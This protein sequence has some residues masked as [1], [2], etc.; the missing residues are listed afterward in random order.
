MVHFKTFIFLERV[1]M[2]LNYKNLCKNLVSE[3]QKLHSTLIATELKPASGELREFQLKTFDFCKGII[4]KLEELNLPYFPIG[5]TLIGV[6]RH[7]GFVPWDDDFD[8]GMMRSD[9]DSFLDF[10][11]K[12]YIQI[13]SGE[14]SFNLENREYVWNKYMKKY[15]NKHIFLQTPHHTQ[16]IFGTDINNFVN[17]D[18]F[19]HDYYDESLSLEEYNIYINEIKEK[20]EIISN[21][22][23]VLDFYEKER[24][25]NPIFVEKSNKIYY[26]LDNIDNYI[27]KHRGFFSVD[28]IFP[29]RR[30]KFED[31]EIWVQN[32][33]LEY[34]ELQYR[35]C[36]SMPSDIIISPHIDA[37]GKRVKNSY[38]LTY[39][40][41]KVYRLL[42]KLCF[43][44]INEK[45]AVSKSLVAQEL[46]TILLEP[47]YNYKDAY[48]DILAKYEFIKTIKG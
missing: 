46:K 22:Q 6:L 3:Y 9:Y 38:S 16:I 17:I 31:G 4:A 15:P 18:I 2:M 35:N 32:K 13:P 20:K 19:P 11:K 27:L 30:M 48:Y 42:L 37:R 7:Q 21:F 23:K 33:P 5:G 1:L 43:R 14:V 28:M 36:M 10:C 8:I 25:I 44:N 41:L 45:N 34:A 12:N 26:G 47:L 40:K 39:L 29:L 24:K